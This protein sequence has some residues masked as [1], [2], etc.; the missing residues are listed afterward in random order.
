MSSYIKVIAI[1]NLTRDHEMRVTP[2]GT[3]ITQFSV[4]VNRTWKDE[5]GQTKEEVS[6][7]DVEA[8][9]KQGEVIAKHFTKG[10]PIFV[11]GRLKQDRWDDKTSGQKRSKVFI[12]LERFE[13]IGGQRED[14]AGG[15]NG[16]SEGS[17]ADAHEGVEQRRA[18]AGARA[19]G[20]QK[21]TVDEDVPF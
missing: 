1:G 5:S 4:A 15:G 14:G 21:D 13:F 16:S 19:G 3:A 2:K 11:D 17:Q 8:W 9:G 20:A 7:F 18:P 10:K 6:Y 12:V